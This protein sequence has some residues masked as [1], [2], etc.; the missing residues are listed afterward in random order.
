MRRR[1]E[2][3][4]DPSGALV[5]PPRPP[6]TALATAMMPQPGPRGVGRTVHGARKAVRRFRLRQATAA[7]LNGVAGAAETLARAAHRVAGKIA[8][9]G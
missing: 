7:V 3:I 2:P 9:P 8:A 6:R 4:P 5:P 1:F